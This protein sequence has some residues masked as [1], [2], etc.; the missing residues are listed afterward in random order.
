[1]LADVVHLADGWVVHPGLGTGLAEQPIDQ[2][3]L[4]VAQ[5]LDGD[6]AL[7]L[8]VPHLVD[9]AHAAGADAD[10]GLVGHEP[11]TTTRTPTV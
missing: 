9:L 1:M 11:T 2:L 7:Q 10:Q 8:L 6:V 4:L 3:R 5:V